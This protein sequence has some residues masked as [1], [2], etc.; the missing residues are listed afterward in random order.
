MD[1]LAFLIT[2]LVV[3]FSSETIQ[4]KVYKWVDENGKVHYSDKPFDD[5]A[6]ELKINDN[7]NPQ[8]QRA[9]KERA[10]KLIEMQQ[11]SVKNRLETEQEKRQQQQQNEEQSRQHSIACARAKEG[12]RILQMQRPIYDMDEKGERRFI[13]DEERKRE[14]AKYKQVIADGCSE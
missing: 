7:V 12:L 8:Q 10:K 14:I 13:S 4:A 5:K 2:I 3:I 1:K 9:A 6:K 11:R